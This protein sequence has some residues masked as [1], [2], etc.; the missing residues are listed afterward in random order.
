MDVLTSPLNKPSRFRR[1]ALSSSSLTEP[2]FAPN[3][4]VAAFVPGWPAAP[5]PEA[6]AEPWSTSIAAFKNSAVLVAVALLDVSIQWHVYLTNVTWRGSTVV[7][8]V[9]INA[10]ASCRHR[11]RAQIE[12]MLRPT[13]IWGAEY[14]HQGPLELTTKRKW[15][16][17]EGQSCQTYRPAFW[18]RATTTYTI[19][20]IASDSII[21]VT[22]ACSNAPSIMMC[23]Q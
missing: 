1:R 6:D 14:R 16:R 20:S 22:G 19:F 2:R 23:V 8:H 7:V 17:G 3:W 12:C 4:N 13:R 5:P 11:G 9:S 10:A 21:F 18:P 15:V